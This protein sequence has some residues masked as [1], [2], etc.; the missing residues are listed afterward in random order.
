MLVLHHSLNSKR[1]KYNYNFIFPLDN[2]P[3]FVIAQFIFL[4][5][6]FP[7]TFLRGPV[8]K[9]L[10]PQ[11]SQI[12]FA[13][14]C[15]VEFF[16]AH[17]KLIVHMKGHACREAVSIQWLYLQGFSWCKWTSEGLLEPDKLIVWQLLWRQKHLKK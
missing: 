8:V 13:D 9:I 14:L 12:S 10:L 6:Y 7:V 5:V 2:Y 15:L 4:V 11:M 17:F 16:F 1:K 3:P